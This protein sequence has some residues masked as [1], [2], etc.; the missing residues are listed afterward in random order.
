MTTNKM[1]GQLVKIFEEQTF[2]GGFTKREF[3]IRTDGKY[4]Q[5]ILFQFNKDRVGKL[6]KFREGDVV[7][8]D[9]SINGREHNGRYYVS[10]IA[11][12]IACEGSQVE[13]PETKPEKNNSVSDDDNIP[14]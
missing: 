11:W 10:L 14:F 7:T 12:S 9:F 5:D 3:V 13:A 1:T 4:P 2:N 8:V 6:D